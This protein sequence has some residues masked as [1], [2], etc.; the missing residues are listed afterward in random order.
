[1]QTHV[2]VCEWSSWLHWWI[3]RILTVIRI[4][5]VCLLLLSLIWSFIMMKPSSWAPPHH[6]HHQQQLRAHPAA[7]RERSCSRPQSGR[8]FL[9]DSAC[10]LQRSRH[11]RHRTHVHPLELICCPRCRRESGRSWDVSTEGPS[12]PDDCSVAF[13]PIRVQWT[14]CSGVQW[15]ISVICCSLRPWTRPARYD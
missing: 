9:K 4:K 12:C 11:R 5:N 15:I 13:R 1:M 10:P 3:M 14:P 7:W 2:V 6:L 8:I